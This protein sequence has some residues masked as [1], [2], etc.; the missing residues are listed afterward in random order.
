MWTGLGGERVDYGYDSKGDLISV[1]R[2][3]QGL[4]IETSYTYDL[5]HRLTSVTLPNQIVANTSLSDIL[6][7]VNSNGDSRGNRFV[8][9]YDPDFEPGTSK[10]TSVDQIDGLSQTTVT[11][12]MGRPLVVVDRLGRE[13]QFTYEGTNRQPATVQLQDPNR[14]LIEYSYD[15]NGNLT[16]VVDDIR[17]GEDVTFQYD[18]NNNLIRHDDALGVTTQYVYNEF[19]QLLSMTRALGLPEQAIWSYSYDASTG[20][21]TQQVD[22]TMV[23]TDFEHDAIGNVVQRTVAPGTS[24]ASTSEFVYDAFSRLVSQEDGVGR[25][26]QYTYNGRDQV[27]S[28]SHVGASFSLVRSSSFDSET[29]RKTLDVDFNSNETSYAYNEFTGDLLEIDS[30][31]SV[32]KLTYDR[33]WQSFGIHGSSREPITIRIRCFAAFDTLPFRRV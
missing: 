7:R 25:V 3:R 2:A 21:Q 22:P 18:A 33:F 30:S 14:P 19:N 23:A 28:V 6:G 20:Y 16:K 17:G 15:T 24:D 4:G 1:D 32:V 5:D 13:I 11:D 29:G 10:I 8:Q 27:T 12:K 31:G 26:T 9:N